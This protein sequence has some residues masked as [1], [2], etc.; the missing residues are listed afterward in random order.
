MPSA[1]QSSDRNLSVQADQPVGLL[2]SAQSY[3][4][5]SAQAAQESNNYDISQQ[6][7]EK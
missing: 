5:Q 2:Y 7:T 6:V 3:Q 4:W 1:S